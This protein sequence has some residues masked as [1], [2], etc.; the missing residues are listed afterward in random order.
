MPWISETA[1]ASP[2]RPPGPST[3]DGICEAEFKAAMRQVAFSV[4]VVTCQHDGARDGLAATSI[5]PVSAHPPVLLVC[6]NGEASALPPILDS[7]AFAVNYLTE[8]QHP[9]AR[10]FSS[11]ETDSERR[12]GEGAWADLE[13][14]AP[15]LAG[16]LA[17][18]DCRLENSITY[19]SH[20]L[21]F[22][23]VV[24]TTLLWDSGLLYRDRQFRRLA[25]VS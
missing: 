21:L 17:S 9:V 5:C 19:G 15:V 4:A 2:E 18:F 12:F 6:V 20:R 3:S 7:G 10:V 11:A 23:R 8:D 16:A 1:N 22:G 25:P 13:T 24:A 14:G